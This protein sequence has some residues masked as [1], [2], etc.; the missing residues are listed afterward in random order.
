[1]SITTSPS[2]IDPRIMRAIITVG[3]EQFTFDDP[4]NTANVSFY[5]NAKGTKFANPVQNECTFVIYN[6]TDTHKNYILTE[7]SPFNSNADN[8]SMQI[9]AGR[10][11]TGLS[12]V[13]AGEIT[14]GSSGELPDVALTL[15][16]AT[17]NKYKKSIVGVNR[18][19]A[20]LSVISG[21]IASDMGVSLQFE[22]NDKIIQNY[23]H[24]GSQYGEVNNLNNTGQ[25]N[26]YLDDNKLVV[27]PNNVALSNTVVIID[28]SNMIG[29]PQISEEGITVKFLFNNDTVLGGGVRL[30]SNS[31]PA[32]NGNYTI[33]KLDFDISNRDDSFYYTALCV[34][35]KLSAIIAANTAVQT[36][37]G[38]S[39]S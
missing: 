20:K 4:G 28:P 32:L 5:M 26:A 23:S 9:Y 15:K 22:A 10:V 1:M 29:I 18:G 36:D 35:A 37:Q 27:K 11:S 30:T 38:N 3:T 7:T 17:G 12:L 8:K 39:A 25:V 31:N 2:V 14:N 21:Q 6:L 16:S 13:Y 33:S 34:N 24:S 19:T